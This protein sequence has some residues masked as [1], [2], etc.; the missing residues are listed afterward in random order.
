MPKNEY[1]I[2]LRT[3]LLLYVLS[4]TILIYAAVFIYIAVNNE[5]MIVDD[6]TRLVSASAGE[7]ANKVQDELD[8]DMATCRAL[9][10]SFKGYDEIP[11]R[12]REGIYNQIMKELLIDNPHFVSVW[13]SWELNALDPAFDQEHGRIRYTY[14]VQDNSI[15]YKKETLETDTDA[16]SGI[17]YDIKA[18]PSEV[19][20][21]PYFFSY[22][23]NVEDQILEASVCVPLMEDGRFIGLVGSDVELERFHDIVQDIDLF[24]GSYAVMVSNKGNIVTH[25]DSRLINVSILDSEFGKNA[26]Y[27]LIDSISSGNE[28]TLDFVKGSGLKYYAFFAPYRIGRSNEIWYIATVVPEDVII[29]RAETLLYTSLLVGVIGLFLLLIIIWF[30]SN[31][32]TTPLR[33]T[34]YVLNNL[35]VG[36]VDKTKEI[37]VNTRDELAEM[38]HALNKLSNGLALNAEFANEIGKGNLD[39]SFKPLGDHDVLGNALLK[40]RNN[41][42]DLRKLTDD[43]KWTTESIVKVSE[44]LQGE[45]S[46]TE[47]A[48]QVLSLL[49]EILNIQIGS[50]YIED[51][52]IYKQ[53][54]TYAYDVR[55][56]NTNEFEPGKGLVGQAALEKKIIIFTDIPD[57]YITIKSGLGE[58]KPSVVIIAPLIYQD[59]VVGVIELGTIRAFDEI[60]LK[61]INQVS[62]NIAIAFQ[63]IRVRTEMK[64]LLA[65][66]QEQAEELRVQQEELREANEDLEQ[67]TKALKKSEVELQQQQEELQVTNE[68]LAEKTKY[69][70]QQKAEIAE[71]NLQL[72]NAKNDL[73]RKAEELAIASKYKSEFLANMSH[74][75]RTPLNSLLILSQSMGENTEGNLNDDQVE[76]AKIIYKSGTDLLTMINDILD[77]SKIESGKMTINY[78]EVKLKDISNNIHQYFK[79]V[80]GQKGISF[81]IEI[82]PGIVD[83]IYSD[84]QKIEQIIKNFVS[85]AIKFTKEGGVTV[86]FSKA[87]AGIDLSRSNLNP[88]NTIAISVI[89]T[90]IGI[91]EDKQKVI[92]EAFQQVDGST[93]RLYGGTGLGLSIS[94]ELARILG[95]EIH[96]HSEL[97]KGSTFTVYLP[98]KSGEGGEKSV[99]VQRE[100][101]SHHVAVSEV[102]DTPVQEEKEVPIVKEVPVIEQ[103]ISD[104]RN[105]IKEK[106][107]VVLIIEDDPNF[108]RILVKQCHEKKFKCIASPTGEEGLELAM[109]HL[110]KAIILDIKLPGIDG[111]KVLDILKKE[112]KTRHIPVH[113]MSGEDEN[114]DA[115]KKGA[116]GYLTKPIASEDLDSAFGK[117]EG[118]IK[119]KMGSLL[120]IEDDKNLRKSIKTLIGEDDVKISDVST[121]KEAIEIIKKEHFDCVVLDLGLPDMSGIELINQLEAEDLDKPPII[122]YTGMDL[123]KEENDELRKHAETVII[124]GVKSEERLLDETALFLHRVVEE[125]PER[126]QNIIQNLYNT[127]DAFTGKRVLVV[128]D[129]M[130][131]VFALTKILKEKGINVLRADNGQ[132]ALDLAGKENNIDLILM[133][134]MMPVMDGYETMKRIRKMK[135][136]E[137]VPIIALTAKA[138][139]EDKEKCINAGANDYLAKPI[140]VEKLL[141]LMR[142]WLY[143]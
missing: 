21:E 17:Y 117:L 68:E 44:I 83:S 47:L 82:E 122:V 98:V 132:S 86:K 23:N 24:E 35:S 109:K 55:K 29:Q 64:E 28:F 115:Y 16:V 67:Q 22:T 76:S 79:H 50:I 143:K 34:T 99:E 45:K 58:I 5:K 2:K 56:A 114:F 125:M 127:E 6:A 62:E 20:T 8:S 87:V 69:L 92:F 106:D 72:E 104:D 85:N 140:D 3:K 46:A 7:L 42:V 26:E 60:N 119:R 116:I 103:F 14:W 138:M 133:D 131:N 91:P 4:T 75:L 96:L 141:S 73:E 110:P 129:D 142:V 1:K 128:D 32:I 95:G 120:I 102:K 78:E 18:S 101:E 39:K 15:R 54:G 65:K 33:K 31:N 108:A 90:G 53:T 130:R 43:N 118:Y 66:T 111:W 81:D 70:E 37:H 27:N 89:D 19:I 51:N 93:S 97:N 63:S 139:K 100:E 134:I 137:K 74:E 49:A 10:N 105:K 136:Y 88:D 80:T 126:Q 124:K 59:S 61:F 84:Q 123:T 41:L 11:E 121:G 38:A 113:I 94:R 112:P 36:K 57:D 107:E 52:G 77:L 48:S 71:K 40:M 25:P 135:K 30:I 9:A 12:Q 13:A